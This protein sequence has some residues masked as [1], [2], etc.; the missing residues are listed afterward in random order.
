MINEYFEIQVEESRSCCCYNPPKKEI[1]SNI[2]LTL[3][4]TKE[5]SIESLLK[6]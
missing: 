2:H 3:P 6:Y 4:I 1:L 5:E